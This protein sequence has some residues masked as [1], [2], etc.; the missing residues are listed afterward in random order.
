M[1][2]NLGK[3]I[4]KLRKENL[5]SLENLANLSG[6]SKSYLWELE[7]KR[8]S[9]PTTNKLTKIATALGVTIEYL[10]GNK[11]LDN[12]VLEKALFEKFMRLSDKDKK[13]IKDIIE[14]WGQE[15]P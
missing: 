2:N 9:N 14:L 4:R 5:F 8:A 11:E 12:S 3:K 10:A 7:N 15:E 1:E 13:R 6:M